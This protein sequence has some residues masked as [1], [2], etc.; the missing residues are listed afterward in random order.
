MFE[1]QLKN[2]ST[3]IVISMDKTV[4]FRMETDAN[5]IIQAMLLQQA[6]K[7]LKTRVLAEMRE[8]GMAIPAEEKEENAELDALKKE[9]QRLKETMEEIAKRD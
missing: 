5:V 4:G 7:E 8:H 3:A 9:N 1:Q 6:G 2:A